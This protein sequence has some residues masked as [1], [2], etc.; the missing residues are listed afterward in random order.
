[1]RRLKRAPTGPLTELGFSLH[2]S[3]RS[4]PLPCS[5]FLLFQVSHQ[6]SKEKHVDTCDMVLAPYSYSSHETLLQREVYLLRTLIQYGLSLTLWD[7]VRLLYKWPILASSR[8]TR[9]RKNVLISK[10]RA[11]YGQ[12]A[13]PISSRSAWL[14]V[15]CVVFLPKRYKA[16]SMAL[17]CT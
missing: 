13:L 5:H 14:C 9:P 3:F 10:F 4:F 16:V 1:M 8:I 11:T 7:V 15:R 12:I 6:F 2:Q 17:V